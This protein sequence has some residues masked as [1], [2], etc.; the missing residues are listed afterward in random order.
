MNLYKE[1]L[2]I[3][4]VY[5]KKNIFFIKY[6]FSLLI[7]LLA[8]G[9]TR[10]Y[11]YS[12]IS[13]IE[14][15]V[16]FCFTNFLLSL[17][18]LIGQIINSILILF[19]NIQL[20][21]LN[22]GS[23]YVTLTMVENISSWEALGGRAFIY[24]V[25][26]LLLILF[27]FLPVDKVEL[28]NYSKYKSA[29]IKYRLIT[30]FGNLYLTALFILCEL[31]LLQI[32]PIR[33]SPSFSTYELLQSKIEMES[34]KKETKT[35]SENLKHEFYQDGVKDFIKKP[36]NLGEKPNVILIFTEGLSQHIIDDTRNITPTIK[37]YQSKSITF[38]NYYN[39]TFATYRGI[40]SQL[41]SGYQIENNSRNYLISLPQMFKKQ[42]YKT[43]FI[44]TEPKN[45]EFSEY[46]LDLGFD[47]IYNSK[48]QNGQDISFDKEAYEEL[49]TKVE[50]YSKNESHYFISM[51]TFGTHVGMNGFDEKFGDGNDRVLNRFFEMDQQFKSFIDRFNSSPISDN[52]ILVFT[53]DHATYVDDEYKKA[54]PN[55]IRDHV[56]LDKVPLIIYY[57][58]VVPQVVDVNGKNTLNMAPTILDLLDYSSENYFL[59]TSLFSG[60]NENNILSTIYSEGIVLKSTIHNK[61]SELSSDELKIVKQKV[62][63]YFKVSQNIND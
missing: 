35:K 2:R 20:I 60:N 18:K 41:F 16:I 53:T 55:V 32:V 22:F 58:G 57:K 62:F 9:T 42:G 27:S 48:L 38:N 3:K 25:A 17:N 6:A 49:F 51:Y 44:N 45:S 19:F 21:V 36:S 28:I 34:V 8:V 54:F 5:F 31:I 10:D 39:H 43:A 12:L 37:E 50:N 7:S 47:K 24:I 56:S 11:G 14:L 1:I 4:E 29:K 59:G 23:S 15:V 33:F 40:Q 63:N 46:L 61:I 26:I 13:I 52:T 30:R